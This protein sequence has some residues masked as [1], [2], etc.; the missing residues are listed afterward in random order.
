MKFS[1]RGLTLTHTEQ[2]STCASNNRQNNPS[3]HQNKKKQYWDRIRENDTR[4]MWRHDSANITYIHSHRREQFN[5]FCNQDW[6]SV[7]MELF[8]WASHASSLALVL[9]SP[10]ESQVPFLFW[11]PKSLICFSLILI[12]VAVFCMH[13][14]KFSLAYTL[15]KGHTYILYIYI[16]MEL[17]PADFL[18][19][20]HI[21][22]EDM[23]VIEL[24]NSINAFI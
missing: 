14:V 8:P 23:M 16:Y 9:E 4:C 11:H 7:T 10:Q 24:P 2:Y 18:G 21:D 20:L 22:N 3:T 15:Y 5:I 6:F 19:T 12:I 13:V 1:A 17:N